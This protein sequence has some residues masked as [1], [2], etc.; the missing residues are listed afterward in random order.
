M[1]RQPDGQPGSRLLIAERSMQNICSRKIAEQMCWEA[2]VQAHQC[3]SLP[4]PAPT[5]LQDHNYTLMVVQ[6]PDAE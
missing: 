3:A 5:S 2:L 1:A 6:E 4:P